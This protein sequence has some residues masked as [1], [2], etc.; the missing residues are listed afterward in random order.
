MEFTNN[1]KQFSEKIAKL[2]D[3]VSTE[4]ATK[5]SL[6]M[7]FFQQILGYDVFNPQE[8]V[9]EYT[10]SFGVKKDA[11]I[12]YAILK[13]GKPT[14]LVEAKCV[15]E[16]ISSLYDSQLAMYLNAS[17][18][19]FGILTNGIVYKFYT[20]LE[21]TNKMDRTPF[22]EINLLNLKES[23]IVELKKFYKDQFNEEN[24]FSTASELK[25][26]KEIK[27][28][29]ASQLDTP[30]DEFIRHILSSGVYPGQKNQSVIEKFRAIIKKSLNDYMNE[31]MN[32]KIMAALKK[33]SS[34]AEP[35][36]KDNNVEDN[37]SPK[38]TDIETTMEE[39]E[40]FYI[41]KSILSEVVDPTRITYKDTR[42]YMNILLDNNSWKWICRVVVSDIKKILFIAGE[43]KKEER[44][45]LQNLNDL[46]KHKEELKASLLR[47]Q[48]Q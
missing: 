1:I 33:D 9:P 5:T 18:A 25:Y 2:K 44:Y 16:D 22:L 48:K 11:R 41:I 31:A 43:N 46:F 47:Y 6:I 37:V 13:E 29:F 38:D 8:F 36:L 17:Q 23:H 21:E 42:S 40:A 10:S 35:S 15:A 32:E 20:D 28:Y 45:D 19:K 4:E 26:S 24:I 14:I 34:D 27:K 7:P 3:L 12:D 30:S 39:I